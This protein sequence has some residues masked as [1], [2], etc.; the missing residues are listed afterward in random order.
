MKTITVF[1]S[2]RPVEG[3]PEFTTAYEVGKHLA[4]AGFSV[5]NGGYG[6]IMTASARGSKEAGGSTIGVTADQLRKGANKWIDQEIR[7]RDLVERL[8][9]LVELGDG[10]VVLKGGT[11]TLLELAC[12]WEFVNKGILR[13]K[14]IVVVGSFWKDVIATLSGEAL[15]EGLGDCTK[16]I[17]QVETPEE[18]ANILR[19]DFSDHHLI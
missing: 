9:K 10:Y 5:C 18:C 3:D 16:F 8:L 17:Q 14:P 13:V 2:S 11:G 6:G 1:G 4:K 19:K 7:K 15:W 12:V